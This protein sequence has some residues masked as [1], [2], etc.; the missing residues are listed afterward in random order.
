[1]TKSEFLENL[2]KEL[3][4]LE[5]VEHVSDLANNGHY[6]EVDA[7]VAEIDYLAWEK[8][9]D[10]LNGHH[11]NLEIS[12]IPGKRYLAFVIY[13]FGSKYDEC[14]VMRNWRHLKEAVRGCGKAGAAI[15]TTMED[16]YIYTFNTFKGLVEGREA[17]EKSDE[18]T[19][20][21]GATE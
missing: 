21:E 10:S 12:E 8:Y 19:G 20:D 11:A 6:E 5:E 13:L 3:E 15:A 18:E 16:H 2:A 4:R 14:Y 17:D 1:M 7:I 9:M